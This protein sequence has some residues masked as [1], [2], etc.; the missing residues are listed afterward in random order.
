MANKWHPD[1]T[2]QAG[3]VQFVDASGNL[4]G[5][6]VAAAT[7]SIRLV[8]GAVLIILPTTDPAVTG[9]LWNNAGT[10]SISA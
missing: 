4:V 1:A 2:T 8:N 10:I 5:K 6:A 7:G 9:A 3:S